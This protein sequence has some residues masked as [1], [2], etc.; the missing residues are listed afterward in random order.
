[1]QRGWLGRAYKH[2]KLESE[3]VVINEDYRLELY[4]GPFK[5]KQMANIQVRFPLPLV[6]SAV[7]MCSF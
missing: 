6:L 2:T 5:G 7:I 4:D 1:M 3:A